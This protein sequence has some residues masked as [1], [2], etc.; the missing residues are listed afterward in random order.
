MNYNDK[1]LWDI[2]TCDLSVNNQAITPS[3]LFVYHFECAPP[4]CCAQA[5]IITWFN[6]PHQLAGY[7]KFVILRIAFGLMLKPADED[8]DKWDVR[9]LLESSDGLYYEN[10]INIKMMYELLEEIDKAFD[11]DD[12]KC[13]DIIKEVSEKFN[14]T[15]SDTPGYN[16]GFELLDGIEAVCDFILNYRNGIPHNK[17][18]VNACN[19][20]SF[21]GE[22]IAEEIYSLMC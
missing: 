8:F 19:R 11:A 13:L 5:D 6:K 12:D 18:F 7:V 10:F 2:A 3:S 20:D 22:I 14:N 21:N 4:P 15:W 17:E 16:F 9:E 1:L